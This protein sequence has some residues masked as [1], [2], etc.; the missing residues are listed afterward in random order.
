MTQ[1]WP[2]TVKLCKS[3]F[4]V[5]FDRLITK[6]LKTYFLCTF[7]D[8][9]KILYRFCFKHSFTKFSLVFFPLFS[10]VFTNIC[11]IYE[12]PKIY[13]KKPK[14]QSNTCFNDNLPGQCSAK[15]ILFVASDVVPNVYKKSWRLL[16]SIEIIPIWNTWESVS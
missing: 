2:L 13:N 4:S 16:S 6:F 7:D 3:G 15:S 9:M 5:L 8:Q 11:K 1:S 14:T 10:N 12:L